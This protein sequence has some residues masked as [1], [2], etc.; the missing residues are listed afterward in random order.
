MRKTGRSNGFWFDVF[1]EIPSAFSK[2]RTSGKISGKCTARC[3][4]N[5][6][7]WYRTK[8]E[9]FA[10]NDE[11]WK[12]TN[13]RTNNLGLSFITKKGKE[14]ERMI[15]NGALAYPYKNRSLFS[16]ILRIPADR[17]TNTIRCLVLFRYPSPFHLFD[18]SRAISLSL[19]L[20]F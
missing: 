9:S 14:K 19:S 11:N 12:A 6:T 15:E 7:I 20:S 17:L 10:T 13:K 3:T 16:L 5:L 1:R 4:N 8:R 2:S 18:H